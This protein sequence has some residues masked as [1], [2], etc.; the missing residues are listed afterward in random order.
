MNIL[1]PLFVCCLTTSCLLHATTTPDTELTSPDG[2]ASVTGQSS[3]NPDGSFHFDFRVWVVGKDGRRQSQLNPGE[4]GD[5]SS[6]PAG[7]R[8]SPDSQWLVRT[9]KIAAGESTL[10]LYHRAGDLFVPATARQLGD[11]A[12]D[13]FLS[14]P[15]S[16]DV[17]REDLSPET[18]LVGG[19]ESNYANLDEHWPDSRYL[20]ID[21]TS[22]ESGTY[23]LGPWRCVYDTQTGEFSVP[24]DAVEFNEGNAEKNRDDQ[25]AWMAKRHTS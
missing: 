19:M 18:R 6:Y 3:R 24:P 20:V 2:K 14:R 16:P 13:Y 10:F 21:L 15:G 25:R 5:S 23:P 11:L 4:T 8:F 9:Q 17:D 12:W 22:G 1:P 7:F